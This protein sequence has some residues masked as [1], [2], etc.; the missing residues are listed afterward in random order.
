MERY[1]EEHTENSA[2]QKLITLPYPVFEKVENIPWTPWVMDGV[3][4]KLLSVDKR[5]GGFTCMLRVAPNTVAPVH[6]H[7]GAI[8]LYVISGDI[9]YDADDIGRAGDYMYEAAGDIHSPKSDTGCV[10]FIVFHGPIAGLNS[11]G[12]I[13]AIVDGEFMLDMAKKDNVAARVYL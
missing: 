13:A 11:D 8:E 5:S 3:E 1:L 9:Y 4:Y 7:L 6:K 12:S 2:V 10:L